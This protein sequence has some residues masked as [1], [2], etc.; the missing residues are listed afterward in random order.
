[1]CWAIYTDHL[2]FQKN[3]RL[4]EIQKKHLVLKM[5]L[6]FI[7]DLLKCPQRTDKR[8]VI[9]CT[10]LDRTYHPYQWD[11]GYQL[12]LFNGGNI[13]ELY[14]CNKAHPLIN[15]YRVGQ[16]KFCGVCR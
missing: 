13:G 15:C 8:N 9:Q 3:T 11:I 12:R 4:F 2:Y 1:M 10:L 5:N 7:M 6:L 16:R 14:A